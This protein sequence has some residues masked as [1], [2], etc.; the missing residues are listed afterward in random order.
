[1][2]LKAV[3]SLGI[4]MGIKTCIILVAHHRQFYNHCWCFTSGYSVGWRIDFPRFSKE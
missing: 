2:D 4:Y 3:I 1:V